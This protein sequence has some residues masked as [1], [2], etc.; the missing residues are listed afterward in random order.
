MSSS[1]HS[2]SFFL[3]P[4]LSASHV[5]LPQGLGSTL[6][7][8][9]EVST[10]ICKRRSTACRVFKGE[11]LQALSRITLT[12]LLYN[13]DVLLQVSDALP[14]V[15][16]KRKRSRGQEKKPT[17]PHLVLLMDPSPPET[18]SSSSPKARVPGGHILF[19]WLS[20]QALPR[21]KAVPP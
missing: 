16:R 3:F 6:L 14:R 4:F 7:C 12:L 15:R 10:A 8:Q 18:A 5:S 1:L 19:S 13:L 17:L 20:K 11:H 2:P 9:R 21:A